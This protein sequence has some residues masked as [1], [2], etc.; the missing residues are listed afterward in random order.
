ME[1]PWKTDY[2]FCF[3]FTVIKPRDLNY[4]GPQLRNPLKADVAKSFFLGLSSKSLHMTAQI[5][6]C[7]FVAGQSIP[8]SVEINNESK[9]DVTD[10]VVEL[11][12]MIYYNSDFPRMRTRKR[13]ERIAQTRH[14]GVPARNKSETKGVLVI[15]SVPPTNTGTCR[16]IQIFYELHVTAKTSGLHRNLTIML[17][18]TIGTGKN[19]QFRF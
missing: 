4:E 7:G 13:E 9:V 15:P 19:S 6:F 8:I 3:A 18:I 1:R 11:V 2:K 5:P 16:T 10:I 17:P 12:K 14:E